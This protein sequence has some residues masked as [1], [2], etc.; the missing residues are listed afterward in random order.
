[1][2]DDPQ[3]HVSRQEQTP[4]IS[5][6]LPVSSYTAYWCVV[7]ITYKINIDIYFICL[8]T[9]LSERL[10]LLPSYPC[11]NSIS[12]LPVAQVPDLSVITN[13]PSSL[14]QS[15]DLR[16]SKYFWKTPRFLSLFTALTATALVQTPSSWACIIAFG[17]SPDSLFP[18]TLELSPQLCRIFLHRSKTENF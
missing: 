1:M 12:R 5:T 7:W 9:F 10:S 2:A 13:S 8:L 17:S 14:P 11:Q 16:K 18:S 6:S 15:L 3:M 4:L